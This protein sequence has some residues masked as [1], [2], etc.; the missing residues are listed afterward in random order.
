MDFDSIK[1]IDF[2]KYLTPILNSILTLIIALFLIRIFMSFTSKLI[3]ITKFNEQKEKTIK[4]IVDSV[5]AYLVL[6][7]VILN[8]IS[9]FGLIKET[10]IITGAGIITLIAGFG[11]QNLIRDVINGFFIL[12]ERQMKVGDFVSINDQYL[13]VVEEIGLRSTAIREWSMKKLYIPNGQIK[14]LKNYYKEKA[15]VLLEVV[16]PFEED[17]NLVENTIKE[18]CAYIN[19]EYKDKL[20]TLGDSNYSAF[21]LYGIVSLDGKNGGAKY[22]IA[23]V[24]KP[25]FQW[26]IRNRT[27]ECLLH[28]FK[29]KNISIAY[30][31][32]SMD[33]R[34]N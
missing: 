21:R 8:T 25:S 16:I 2:S 17:H 20:Y 10:T 1:A 3:E 30:P 7:L 11:S 13:G 24:V 4:S 34:S 26:F 32:V 12:F 18:V 19:E 6:T 33:K 5:F 22:L 31:K 27:Y 9:K 15:K 29:E 28:T 14:T 23:G